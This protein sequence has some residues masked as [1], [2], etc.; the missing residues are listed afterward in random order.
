MMVALSCE[1]NFLILSIMFNIF[2]FV[3]IKETCER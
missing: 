2:N 3:E 1:V